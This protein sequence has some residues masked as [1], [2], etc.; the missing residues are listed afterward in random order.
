MRFCQ[1]LLICWKHF[2]RPFCWSLFSSF[3]AFLMMSVVSQKEPSF[4]RW[5]QSKEQVKISWSQV[6]RVRGMLQC[7]HAVIYE[8]FLDSKLPEC[9]SIVVKEKPRISSL[10]AG[11][12]P[13]GRIPK[14]TKD[15]VYVPFLIHS[16]ISCKLYQRIP[17]KFWGVQ[18]HE[19]RL[20]AIFSSLLLLS[21]PFVQMSSSGSCCHALS[22]SD[23]LVRWDIP[24]FTL[25]SKKRKIV[26]LHTSVFKFL[27]NIGKEKFRN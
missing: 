1:R 24:K 26:L 12:I 15:A 8:E 16:I 9:W 23:T 19:I 6:G 10:F 5:L 27:D 20:C 4:P 25:I 11:A 3:I 13:F 17:G 14:A 18:N 21:P 22:T 2:R 7:C